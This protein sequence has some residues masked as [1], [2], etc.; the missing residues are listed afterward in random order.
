MEPYQR[1]DSAVIS[2]FCCIGANHVQRS[3]VLNRKHDSVAPGHIGQFGEQF[4]ALG[5]T[6]CDGERTLRK[7]CY[8][9]QLLKNMNLSSPH[10]FVAFGSN[11]DRSEAKFEVTSASKGQPIRRRKKRFRILEAILEVGLSHSASVQA[12][13]R[14]GLLWLRLALL[15]R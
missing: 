1:R 13:L 15:R 10:F 5:G 9:L 8:A 11:Y 3:M 14:C 6:A 7:S 2:S 12:G 4:R